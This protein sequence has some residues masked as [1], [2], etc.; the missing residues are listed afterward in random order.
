MSRAHSVMPPA[1]LA[2][3]LVGEACSML[4]HL[5][6]NGAKVPAATA[7]SVSK[8]EQALARGERID[9]APLT[10]AHER[11]ARLVAPARPGTIYIMDRVYHRPGRL[12]AFGTLDLVRQMV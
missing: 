9:L 1:T 3:Q 10:S 11:L 12:G 5:L 8:M 2:E 6:S 7:Q 4:R